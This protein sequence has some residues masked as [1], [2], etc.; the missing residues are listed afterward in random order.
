[1]NPRR[2]L[3]VGSY[4]PAPGPAAAATVG[5]VRRAWAAGSEVVVAS[6]R[7]ERGTPRAGGLRLRSRAPGGVAVPT[8]S[9]RR[10]RGVP[11][12]GMAVRRPSR[13]AGRALARALQ[14]AGRAELV[15]T[16]PPLHGRPLW[17]PSLPCGPRSPSS[18]PARRRWPRCCPAAVPATAGAP[19]VRAIEPFA[20]AGLREANWGAGRAHFVGPMEPGE[21]LLVTRC[22]RLVGR[23][24]RRVLGRQEPVVRSYLGRFL[25]PVLVRARRLFT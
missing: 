11:G 21:L 16:G 14:G 4:P 25:R 3:V 19:L 20:A 8:A 10:G 24:A 18:P 9:L 2:C 1:M 6:P 22:R 13:A 15:V 23:F 5:A 17:P 7:P 12:A